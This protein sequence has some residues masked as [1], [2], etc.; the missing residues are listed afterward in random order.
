MASKQFKYSNLGN[1]ANLYVEK[2]FYQNTNLFQAKQEF[3]R[4]FLEQILSQ[5]KLKK[6]KIATFMDVSSRTLDRYLN[7][8]NIN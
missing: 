5:R 8:D 3:T 4:T 2:A 7:S 6:R 1:I